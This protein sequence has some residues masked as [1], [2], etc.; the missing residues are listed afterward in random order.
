MGSGEES[1]SDAEL[2]FAFRKGSAAALEELVGRYQGRLHGYLRAMTGS[3][4][5]A[6]DLFQETWM[7][8]IR[9]PGSF[10]GGAFNAWLWR[11]ARNLL[12]DRLRRRK[13][14]VSLDDTTPEGT[15]YAALT[16]TTEAGPH[17]EAV[18]AEIGRRIA[19]AVDRLP[20]DQRDVFLL[21]T[22]AGLSFAEIAQLRRV[23][24]NT[25]LGRM[26]YAIQRLRQ[27]LGGMYAALCGTAADSPENGGET[28]RS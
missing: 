20:P 17:E 10:R 3:Q 23:P 21:R 26:H 24:L 27:D 25:A 15:S 28:D 13:P 1:R 9:N 2:L 19:A 4:A 7:R 11:I 22:Q 6:D 8:V 16:P 14:V 18:S 12:V 5:D